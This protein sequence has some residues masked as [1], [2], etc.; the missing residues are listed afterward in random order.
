MKVLLVADL[1]MNLPQFAWLEK[2]AHHADLV[3][4]AGDFL[5]I[6]HSCDKTEQISKIKPIIERIRQRRPLMI[7]CGNHDGDTR[8]PAGEEY[9]A[10]IQAIR[11]E[12]AHP[13]DFGDG[14]YRFTSCIW[15][16][17]PETRKHMLEHLRANQPE[18]GVTW[19]WI[20][21]APPRGSKTAW[22]RNGDAGDPY[23]LKLIGL[24]G[25]NHVLSGHIHDA[26]FHAQGSWGERIGKTWAFNP[27]KQIGDVPSHIEIDLANRKARYSSIEGVELLD[28]K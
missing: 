6:T 5:Q 4:I 3:V 17:G 26:P 7:T 18:E 2:N 11:A 13:T 12:S 19:I 22:T 21:H 14:K 15:W 8:N 1:H 23:L 10:W 20:H 27:G 24:L 28:L 9:A 16:N 25:P